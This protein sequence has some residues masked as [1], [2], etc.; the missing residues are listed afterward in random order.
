MEEVSTLLATARSA[1]GLS[2]FGSDSFMEGL[3]ILVKALR[4]EANLN[5]MGDGFLQGR[6]VGHLKQRLQIED[7]YRRHPEIDDE[8]IAA[9][10]IGISLPRTGST[11]LSFLLGQDE[12]ARYLRSSEASEPCP[13]PCTLAPTGKKIHPDIASN[14]A[15][16]Q[17]SHVP[18]GDDGPAEC[19]DLM[20]LDFKSQIFLAFAQVPSYA[21]WLLNAD[22]TSTYQYQRRALKLLQWRRPSKPWRLKCP[23]HLIYLN[24]LNKAFPD[25]KFVMTHRDPT[26]VMLSVIEVYVD[27]VSRFTDHTDV[28]YLA[29]LNIRQ[30]SE[31]MR[32][33]LAFRDAGNESR[34]YDIHFRAMHNDPVAE[35]RGLYQWLG[36]PLSEQFEIGMKQWWQENS[37]NRE[38]SSVKKPEDY[39]VNLEQLRPLFAEYVDRL[40]AWT[41]KG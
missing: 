13:P 16:G 6:I 3:E 11:A 35:V 41:N 9:P 5:A 2:D 28:A 36:E 26:D 1:T 32:R 38:P 34:F 21:D 29:E 10:L 23:T 19:Q 15:A 8:V 4:D 30:W 27:I 39:G 12:N 37:E 24:D 33:A 18:L 25:A 40:P 14:M 22:L 31:G 20:A 7:W 17:K